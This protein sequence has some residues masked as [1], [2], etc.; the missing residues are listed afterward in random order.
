MTSIALLKSAAFATT[1][2]FD[3]MF[4]SFSLILWEPKLHFTLASLILWKR[5]FISVRFP[6]HREAELFFRFRSFPIHT[7]NERPALKRKLFEVV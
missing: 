2:R 6:R 7:N 5:T 4:V 1:D 3:S